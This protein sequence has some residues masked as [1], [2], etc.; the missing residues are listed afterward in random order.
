DHKES[1][2]WC[3]KKRMNRNYSFNQAIVTPLT[4]VRQAKQRR[5]ASNGFRFGPS[6][7]AISSNERRAMDRPPI[8]R[9][10]I[11]LLPARAL[12]RRTSFTFSC[13]PTRSSAL[14]HDGL[15]PPGPNFDPEVSLE[16]PGDEVKDAP[17][18]AIN[19]GVACHIGF[20]K[21]GNVA[22]LS[23]GEKDSLVLMICLFGRNRANA[24]ECPLEIL[25]GV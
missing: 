4:L 23:G 17:F 14:A 3:H 6:S 13:V 22:D 9:R 20:E 24:D 19:L 5:L 15:L 25:F 16:A 12:P 18:P 2:D 1:V 8:I 7:H 21:Q 11:V 10:A